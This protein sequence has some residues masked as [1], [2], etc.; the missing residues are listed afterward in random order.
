MRALDFDDLAKLRLVSNPAVAG[1]VGYFVLTKINLDKNRY[2]S[3]I[4]AADLSTG[5]ARAITPGPSDFA[6]S[7]SPRGDRLAY[8]SRKGMGKK[9]KGVGLWAIERGGVARQLAV[10][11]LGVV[12]VSWSPCGDKLAVAAYEGD[13]ERDVKHAEGL[14]LWANDFGFAYNVQSHL[15]VV[16]VNSGLVEKMTEGWAKVKHVSW[17]PDCR[18]IAYTVAKEE[19][20]P[21]L[22]DVFV[23]D[24][25]AGEHRTIARGFVSDHHLAWSPDSRAVAL[26]GHRMPRGLSSHNRVW[27]LGLDG[28]EVCLTCGF[29]R[30]AVNTL[31]S[32]VRGPSYT[33]LV[34]WAGDRI[35]F[36]ATV[37]GFAELYAVNLKGEVERVVGGEGAVDEFAVASDG[38]ILYTFMTP[39]A[40]KE[41]YV[42]KE[43][44]A[45]QLTSFNDFFLS[46]VELAKPT[47]FVF[48]ASDGAEIEG[49]VMMPN[50]REGKAPWVL[51]IHGGPKTAWGHGFMFEF[52]LLAAKGFAVVYVNPRGSDGYS[53]EFADIRCKY[54]ERDYRDLME[55]AD[56]AVTAL[57]E[58][59]GERAAVMGGSYGGYMTNWI[60]AHTDRFKAAI[61]Q[62]S[63]AD[64]ISMYATTDIGWYFVQDQ[65]C[66]SPWDNKERCHEKSPIY[67]ADNIK[68]P[69]LITHSAEDYRTWL[70]QGVMF[71][72]ALRLRG[73]KTRLALFPEESHELTR[74]G[75]PKHRIED[76]KEKINWLQKYL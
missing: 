20:R 26:L 30:N 50:R 47:R 69:T 42:Y 43:G 64:W 63:I 23:Y 6:P 48:R 18:Y 2:E 73:V 34:Q 56:Y 29:D 71:F 62:R 44:R 16:D 40:P 65:I 24:V 72:T 17:S 25:K 75:K 12:D 59:D 1:N 7:P 3:S 46:Q 76:L 68:T 57:P 45:R 28:S 74:K 19:L 35:Y 55:A 32:D 52:Q 67:Y 51:Y 41:L 58:L 66:C 21:Y 49:W 53:E 38:S 10:F 11:P 5:E 13:I 60:I 70:D 8:L 4:W 37:G 54:G 33:P 61:T 14:P 9:A 39:T 22:V 31:N 15:Y 36:A 27:A